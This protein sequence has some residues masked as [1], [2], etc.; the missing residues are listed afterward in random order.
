MYPSSV[1][2]YTHKQIASAFVEITKNKCIL[3][4]VI[5]PNGI[6]SYDYREILS[7]NI[8][9][10]LYKIG[11]IRQ[12][13]V[14]I[15]LFSETSKKI[16]C[17]TNLQMKAIITRV[18]K[19][20]YTKNAESLLDN[21]KFEI[22]PK[23]DHVKNTHGGDYKL[24]NSERDMSYATQKPHIVHSNPQYPQY[25]QTSKPKTKY[26]PPVS[27]V[28]NKNQGEQNKPTK[29]IPPIEKFSSKKYIPEF[30][31]QNKGYTSLTDIKQINVDDDDFPDLLKSKKRREP[32]ISE[33]S[34]GWG[35]NKQ[36][37]SDIVKKNIIENKKEIAK[38]VKAVIEV[39]EIKK[40][41]VV[42]T[43]PKLFTKRKIINA[44]V[45]DKTDSDTL[46]SSPSYNANQ[47][48]EDEEE[49]DED[50]PTYDDNEEWYNGYY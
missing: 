15:L 31:P 7:M 35:E 45:E 3:D 20:L 23:I 29:Y 14:K 39:K 12:I 18:W 5:P 48:E 13:L 40:E 21:I 8:D 34:E 22:E 9:C 19:I 30:E 17:F 26:V 38:E 44:P 50:T 37:L 47:E 32:E 25:Q 2:Q 27:V 36:T 43:K 16:E 24:Q 33:L 46:T 4:T 10:K 41:A 42:R 6:L 49:Y 28:N 11:D 1:K